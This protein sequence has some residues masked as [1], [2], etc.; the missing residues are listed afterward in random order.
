MSTALSSIGRQATLALTFAAQQG[1]TVLEHARVETPL[2]VTRPYWPDDSGTAHVILMSPAPG[3]FGGDEW[4]LRIRVRSGAKVR[5]TPQGALRV[6]PTPSAV[7]AL[8][9]VELL[10][11]DGAALS[12]EMEPVIPF[13]DSLLQQTVHLQVAPKGRLL[14]WDAFCSG[15]VMHGETWA[16]RSFSQDLSCW[17]AERLLL[18]DRFHLNPAAL[19]VPSQG[20]HWFAGALWHHPEAEAWLLDS[21]T[22]VQESPAPHWGLDAPD[23]SLLVLRG[24]APSGVAYRRTADALRAQLRSALFENPSRPLNFPSC[25]FPDNS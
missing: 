5:L 21:A 14:Y 15:R 22:A 12:W 2:K 16:F 11:E 8:Q 17:Q 23:P 13:R 25:D 18:R 4:T 1:R 19:P 9:H 20:M 24:L 3:L 10:V 6:H 7:P